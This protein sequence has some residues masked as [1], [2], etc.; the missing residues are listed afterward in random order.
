MH[1]TTKATQ[2]THT[3]VKICKTFVQLTSLCLCTT[4]LLYFNLGSLNHIEY[5]ASLHVSQDKKVLSVPRAK[6][7]QTYGPAVAIHTEGGETRY[8]VTFSSHD[9]SNML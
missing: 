4:V 9:L 8:S 3:K 6:T 1:K 7:R 2:G 5:P